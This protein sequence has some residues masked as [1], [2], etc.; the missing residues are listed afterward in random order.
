MLLCMKLLC[1]LGLKLRANPFHP[2]KTL[3]GD[4]GLEQDREDIK[5]IE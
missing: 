2:L 4:L 3:R 1:T 5:G